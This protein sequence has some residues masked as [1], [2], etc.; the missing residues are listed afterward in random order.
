[1]GR[2]WT[3]ATSDYVRVLRDLLPTGLVWTPD[4]DSRLHRLI[5]GMA[6]EFVRF[7]NRCNTM[8]EEA[9]PATAS[10]QLADWE[11]VLAL[12][13]PYWLDAYGPTITPAE[14]RTAITTRLAAYGGASISYFEGIVTALGATA[15]VSN[16]L[17]PFTWKVVTGEC[18]R[19]DCT[20]HCDESLLTWTAL[21]LYIRYVFESYKPAHT[22]IFWTD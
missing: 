21:G 16:T 7:H 12:P 22:R 14:R 15:T 1:V 9:D 20:G 8:M 5:T 17:S 11:R 18:N 6:V 13:D 3:A 19:L 2:L 4:T 10:E